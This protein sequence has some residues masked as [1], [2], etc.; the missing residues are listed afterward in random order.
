M[1]WAY[2]QGTVFYIPHLFSMLVR[3]LSTLAGKMRYGL[4]RLHTL[5]AS[6]LF[7]GTVVRF[8]LAITVTSEKVAGFGPQSALLLVAGCLFRTT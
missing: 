6:C 4:A 3:M 7:L 1:P 8:A 2:A 5:E